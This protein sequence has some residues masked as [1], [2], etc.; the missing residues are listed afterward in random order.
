MTEQLQAVPAL[1]LERITKC[2]GAVV[3]LA[4]ATLEVQRGTVHGLCGGNGAGKSTLVKVLSGYYPAGTYG[5]VVSV[6][7]REVR[8]ASPRDAR[9]LGI[10]VVPQETSTLDALTVAENITL[11]SDNETGR[12]GADQRDNRRRAAEF[13]E[14]RRIRL[15]VDR[16]AGSLT[17]H[18]RQLVMI[19]RALYTEPVVL[20][21][22]EPT[23]SLS[24]DEVENLFEIVQ[25]LRADGS[26][27]VFITHRLDEV[28]GL[29]DRVSVLRDGRVV[30]NLDT[31]DMTPD[32]IVASMIGRDLDHLFPPQHP[33]PLD[34]PVVLRCRGVD[35]PDMQTPGR[36]IL[37]GVD[38]ELRAGEIVG[39]A[40]L[41]GSGR[42]ELASV[43]YGRH[44]P[45]AGLI[46]V[47]GREVS[48]SAPA[49]ALGLGIGFVTE[50]RKGEGVLP[51][52]TIRENLTL[53]RLRPLSRVAVMN[54]RAERREAELMRT[55]LGIKAPSV[56]TQLRMLS[57]GNQQKA[58]LGRSLLPDP[59]VLILDEPTKGVDVGAKAEIY[60]IIADL[61]ARGVAIL[62]ISSEMAEVASLSHRVLVLRGG[63]ITGELRNPGLT[64]AQ[65]LLAASL[66]MD[67]G[68]AV[69]VHAAPA[70]D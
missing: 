15:N 8:L 56:E 32:R 34:A 9:R 16:L 26:T 41:V 3:A 48:I 49:V 58:V 6:D 19:A 25:G 12:F 7:G 69:P 31:Q 63:V 11:G 14:R 23:S 29:C 47:D 13:L 20:V 36:V 2:F 18:E 38:L 1:R 40:G 5:G 55:N 53:A 30:A 57:G 39:L 67:G 65:L 51:D 10:S 27:C 28:M 60:G 59:R 62:L 50:D 21:L 33:A 46:E 61:A 43:L 22:D 68:A 64:E 66:G 24:S 70:P 45:L 35:V 17:I 4:D 54:R 42:T 52:L 44:R 37:R